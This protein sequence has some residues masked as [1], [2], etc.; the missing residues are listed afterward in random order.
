MY[1][2]TYDLNNYLFSYDERELSGFGEDEV[3]NIEWEND[4]W[5]DKISADGKQIV[6]SAQNDYRAN[7]T[8][9]FM[10]TSDVLDYLDA[11]CIAD[12]GPRPPGVPRTNDTT[13]ILSIRSIVPGQESYICLQAYIKK[14]SDRSGAKDA[15]E[16]SYIFRCPLLLPTR[17]P[18]A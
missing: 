18:G 8:L 17:N 16:R 5:N 3:F 1:L 6:R 2:Q 15:S 12:G 14:P 11:R 13:G 4:W 10:Q 7:L 9:N